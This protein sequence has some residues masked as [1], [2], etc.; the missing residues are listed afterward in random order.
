MPDMPDMKDRLPGNAAHWRV[1]VPAVGIGLAL[2]MA[3]AFWHRP[4]APPPTVLPATTAP[5]TSST[6]VSPPVFVAVHVSGAVT[7]PGLVSVPD[8]S[9]VADAIAAAGGARSGGQLGNINLA[10]PVMDGMHLVVP[11]TDDGL[12]APRSPPGTA[13]GRFPV[14]VNR[15][16]ADELTELPGVGEV[17]AT[18]IMTYRETHGPFGTLEDLLDVPGIG[19]GKLAGLRDYAVVNR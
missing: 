3:F 5:P 2:A 16:E 4:Q 10:A 7:A 14:D 1:V 11:W 18:R 6:V 8:G 19:E 17:L 9:R 12:L 15:A 13:A